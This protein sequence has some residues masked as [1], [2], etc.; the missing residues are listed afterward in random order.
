MIQFQIEMMRAMT[1]AYFQQ[2]AAVQRLLTA[3]KG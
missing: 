2:L 1:L 3:T